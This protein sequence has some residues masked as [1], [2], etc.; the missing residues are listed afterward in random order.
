[1]FS[2]EHLGGTRACRG[3]LFDPDY[4]TSAQAAERL[5]YTIQHVRR[6]IHQGRL[7]GTKIGRD[8]VV[9]RD[10]VEA[11]ASREQVLDLPLARG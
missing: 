3:F 1:M 11:W 10:S 6:L 2:R 8:W 9:R 7:V 5:G 4:I